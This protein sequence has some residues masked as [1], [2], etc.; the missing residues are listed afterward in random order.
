[1]LTGLRRGE[2][3]NHKYETDVCWHLGKE[4]VKSLSGRASFYHP[5]TAS[6]SISTSISLFIPHIF[7][8]GQPN[9]LLFPSQSFNL[10]IHVLIKD[11][12]I[13]PFGS[14]ISLMPPVWTHTKLNFPGYQYKQLTMTLPVIKDLTSFIWLSNLYMIQRVPFLNNTDISRST[15]EKNSHYHIQSWIYD[16]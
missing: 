7:L 11:Y 10:N 2:D 6:L 3:D 8:Y 15:L 12:L 14:R 1:M 5:P 13:L 4:R 9:A 16:I